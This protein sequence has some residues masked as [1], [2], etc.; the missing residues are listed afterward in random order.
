MAR[1]YKHS[2]EEIRAMILHAAETT[3]INEGYAGLNARKIAMDIGYTAGSIYM[4]FEN[5]A[6]IALH[7]NAKTLEEM[8]AFLEQQQANNNGS[9]INTLMTGYFNYA[10]QHSNLWRMLFEYR[11]PQDTRL[12]LWYQQQLDMC[13]RKI[14][15]LFLAAL[16]NIPEP[17]KTLVVQTLWGGMQGIYALSVSKSLGGIDSK[18][19]ESSM[20][21]LANNFVSNYR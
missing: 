15:A 21:L 7:I 14:E 17:D 13:Y 5:M 2:L 10:D 6:E 18:N 11:F 16:P 1:R 9:S 4:I 20:Q 19:I 3:V 12:P 8:T